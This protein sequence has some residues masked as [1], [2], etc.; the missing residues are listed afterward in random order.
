MRIYLALI[1]VVASHAA[2]AQIPRW[3]HMA[4]SSVPAIMRL[5]GNVP[6]RSPLLNILRSKSAVYSPAKRNEIADSL[7]A[8]VI[9]TPASAES[10]TAA[11]GAAVSAL[12]VLVL[13]G[14]VADSGQPYSAAMDWLVRIHQ[15]A[16]SGLLRIRALCA[17]PSLA[18]RAHALNHL[19]NA[20]QARDPRASDAVD[21]LIRD[22]D[23][24]APYRS[25]PLTLA[26]RSESATILR[27]LDASDRVQDEAARHKIKAWARS[28]TP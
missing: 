5:A 4:D 16:A 23:G 15:R 28:K 17:L 7:A 9:S 22:F 18:N 6:D 26:D 10:D 11:Y 21:C 25:T 20:A 12:N 24:L 2:P 19:R 14:V 1:T 8:R 3:A 13:A 27:Q